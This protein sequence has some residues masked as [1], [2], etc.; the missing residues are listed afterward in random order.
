MALTLHF[1][2]YYLLFAIWLLLTARF[3]IEIVR[4]FARSWAPTGARAVTLEVI[5]V[6][7]DPPVKLLRKLIPTVRFGGVGLDLSI[8][9]LLIISYIAMIIARPSV[10]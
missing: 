7:T 9:I 10:I 1:A 8:T 3:V 4:S 6:V 2:L 5:Y